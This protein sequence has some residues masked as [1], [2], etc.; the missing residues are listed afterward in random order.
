MTSTV[1]SRFIRGGRVIDPASGLDSLADVA[2]TDGKVEEIAAKLSPKAGAEIID[3][4]GL[5]VVPGL[6]DPHVHLREPG[7]EHKE[8]IAS[9][10]RSAV[11]GGFTAVCAMPNTSPAI[12][13]PAQVEFVL[14]RGQETGHCRVFTSS[15]GTIG[16]R[17]E[18]IA[19]I[20]EL[21]RAGAVAITDDGDVIQSDD[22]MARVLEG[23]AEHG[24]VFMQ[25]C[26]DTRLA[27]NGQ[28]HAGAISSKYGLKGWP[29]AAED[30]IIE[31]D[32][33]LAQRTGARYHVQ[34]ISSENSVEI[35][36]RA[37]S[38]G[39]QV[40]AEATPHHL[41]LTHE[42]I[43]AVPVKAEGICRSAG[44]PCTAPWS[45]AKVNPP[46]R[47]A[48]D[49]E[50]IIAG[51][52]EG[53]ITVLATDH[54]PHATHEKAL[55]FERAP[56]G[57]IGLEF[58]LSVYAMTLVE[59]GHATWP[60][61]VE[62]M[63]IAPARLLGIDRLGLG[64]ITPGGPA[65][66]TLIDPRAQWTVRPETIVSASRNTPLIGRD[67]SGRAVLTIVGGSVRASRLPIGCDSG[68]FARH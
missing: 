26:Q 62:M 56:M 20:A 9:G 6:I 64:A 3:A 39:V 31:R 25:H 63:T 61:L 4:S 49:R 67:L 28:L 55:P 65:D 14:S 16:R 35:V 2:L 18:A 1:R 52:R 68:R 36:R 33:A 41:L 23:C 40:T 29:R 21:V 46:I 60:K 32:V 37:R 54:A 48:S 66:L 24:V 5:L 13:T 42:I 12:D 45:L 27:H 22:M 10:T 58:A 50:A 19:P 59:P 38:A 17:G 47:E 51:V 30:R 43:D 53:T 57:M 34:H 11:E 8:T 15:A 7:H 44:L